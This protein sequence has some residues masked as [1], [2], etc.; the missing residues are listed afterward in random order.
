MPSNRDDKKLTKSVA[1]T[2]TRRSLLELAGMAAAAAA[3]PALPAQGKTT[4]LSLASPAVPANTVGP[5]MTT[6]ST[7]MSEAGGK[8]LPEEVAEK[9]KQHVLDT[10][11]AMISGSELPPGKSCAGFRQGVRRQ[12][13]SHGGGVQT[14]CAERWKQRW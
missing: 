3:L 2:L 11:A 12:R 6:L 13:G 5:V 1:P 7:Y 4:R 8:A 9:S 10:F 14:S